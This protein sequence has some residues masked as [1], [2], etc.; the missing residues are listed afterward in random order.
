MLIRFTKM[1]GLGNDFMLL[2]LIS[3]DI[4]LG[5]DRMRSLADRRLGIGFDQLLT[6]G[7]PSNPSADFRYRIFNAD[8]AEVEQ[9]G[10][11]ARCVTRFVRDRGL[12][13]KT[14]ITLETSSGQ[15]D[16]KLEK[17]GNIT[18]N[19]GAPRLGPDHIPF[20]AEHSQLTYELEVPA[21]I[22]HCKNIEPVCISA[23]NVGNPHAVLAV[24][25]V[26]SAPVAKL[27]PLIE[28]HSRFPERVNVNF[29]Q[30]LSRDEIALRVYERGVGET[31]ACGTGA[32][33]SV[34][35]GRLIGLLDES[36]TVSLPGGNLLIRWAGNE[37][38][39]YMTGPA[40]RVYEG[41]LHI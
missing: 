40:C 4:H 36:V 5:E 28:G 25:D 8:G 27:G 39:I 16:C 9:C 10:N 12:T 26:S 20:I 33:A 37:S 24:D 41:R 1:H 19:M 22:N 34:V 38:D 21:T 11:G 17:D 14:H 15:I 32:C 30:I 23:I 13:T 6:V 3:Q 35:A 29:M 31:L 7:P 2:D 18:V